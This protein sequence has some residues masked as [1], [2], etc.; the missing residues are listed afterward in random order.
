M[1][2]KTGIVIATMIEALPFIKGLS[3]EPT[4]RKPFPV[5][6]N[7]EFTLIVSGIGKVYAALAA[8]MLIRDSGISALINTGSAGGLR[9][10][11]KTGDIFHI[12]E[13]V[14]YD[15]P[16]L[17]NNEMRII[18]PD[19]FDGFRLASLATLDRPVI[20]AGDRQLV[21]QYADIIDMEGAGFLQACRAFGADAYLW[22][23]VSDTA[24]DT[25]GA[26]IVANIKKLSDTLFQFMKESVFVNF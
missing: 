9:E 17:R 5:Y 2:G 25:S 21:G 3:L 23:I 19:T 4:A 18:K 14:D 12:S 24:E 11:V 10:G 20:T 6:I 1:K 7:N 22:K 8:G 26:D 15:R 13:V 16:K